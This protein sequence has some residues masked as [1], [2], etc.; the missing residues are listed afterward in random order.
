MYIFVIT[1]RDLNENDLK[2]IKD[3]LTSTSFFT[4]D[5]IEIAEDVAKEALTDG[6]DSGYNFVLA[7]H[8]NKPV[9]F[10]CFGLIPGTK[11]SFD[12]YWVA[13][14]ND[15]RSKGIGKRLLAECE[16]VIKAQGGKRI[17]IDTAGKPQYESTRLFYKKC[18]YIEQA[19]LKDFF[20][21]GDDKVIFMK[22]LTE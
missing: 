15:S 20:E 7:E 13:V 3:I 8:E 12:F 5:E 1:F 16:N 17:Y 6:K 19:I 9:G 18:G 10:A 2:H 22:V 4:Q 14:H 11:E 21:K